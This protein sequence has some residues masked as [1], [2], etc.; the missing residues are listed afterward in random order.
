MTDSRL[1]K[2]AAAYL[3]HFGI[4]LGALLVML[5]L[6]HS[7][8]VGEPLSSQTSAGALLLVALSALLTATIPHWMYRFLRLGGGHLSLP[9]LIPM[10]LAALLGPIL[11]TF[12]LPE[13]TLRDW[14]HFAVGVFIITLWFLI[15]T[16]SCSQTGSLLGPV[17]EDLRRLWDRRDL[18]RI[19]L[20]L[21]VLSRYSQTVLGILWII[22]LPLSTTAVLAFVFGVILG[23]QT[24]V[25]YVPFL[26]AA[27]IPYGLFNRGVTASTTVF[28]NHRSLINRIYFPR[29]IVLLVAFGEALVDLAFGFVAMLVVNALFNVWPGMTFVFLLLPLL[30]LSAITLGVMFYV[31]YFSVLIRDVPQ[32]TGVLLQLNFYLLPIIYPIERVPSDLRLVVVLNPLSALLEQCRSILVLNQPP[33]LVALYYPLVF[34]IVLLCSG[35]IFLKQQEHVL[36]DVV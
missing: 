8:P 6:H 20:R 3:D 25:P 7:L 9:L 36:A 29:E 24:E 31:G 18:V 21:Q 11:G 35:Y 12:L 19:W 15:W 13:I 28:A 14:V 2:R 34:A 10:A 23:A 1:L 33:D 22:V 5:Y 16:P 30:I 26:L 4:L 27:I 17:Y 32:L